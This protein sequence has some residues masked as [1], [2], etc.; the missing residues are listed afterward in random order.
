V[1]STGS[2]LRR[3][4]AP[5]IGAYASSARKSVWGRGPFLEAA[6]HLHPC[7]GGDSSKIRRSRRPYVKALDIATNLLVS[8]LTPHGPTLDVPSYS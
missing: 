3:M 6:V 2:A 5:F 4:R 7:N 8:L 1:V